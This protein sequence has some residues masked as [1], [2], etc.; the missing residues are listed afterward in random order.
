MRWCLQSEDYVPAR[1]PSRPPAPA[2]QAGPDGW[3]AALP[4]SDPC[5]F[6]LSFHPTIAGPTTYDYGPNS[7]DFIYCLT[8]QC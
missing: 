6:T 7:I 5:S 3:Q 2:S 8:K 1:P 4:L